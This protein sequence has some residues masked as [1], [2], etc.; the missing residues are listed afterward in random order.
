MK[1]IDQCLWYKSST[2]NDE[3]DKKIMV[4]PLFCKDCDGYNYFCENYYSRGVQDGTKEN[5]KESYDS[6]QRKH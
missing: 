6:T 2:I 4:N 3:N 5:E 1:T